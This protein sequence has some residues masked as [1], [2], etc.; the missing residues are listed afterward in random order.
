MGTLHEALDACL[1][2]D[3]PAMLKGRPGVGKTAYINQ[4]AAKRGAH[5]ETLIGSTMDPT[6]LGYLVVRGDR[7]KVDPPDWAHRIRDSLDKGNPTILF[8]DEFTSM[9]PSVMAAFL[10]VVNE[11]FVG[12]MDIRGCKII[13]AMNPVE[14]AAGG[15]DMDDASRNRW[16]FLEW[17]VD[18][19]EWFTGM[20]T[21][22]G[23]TVESRQADMSAFIVSFLRANPTCLL[24]DKPSG[25]GA[26]ESPRA[27][28]HLSRALSHLENFRSP[29]DA[30]L[31]AHGALLSEGLVGKGSTGVLIT[32]A[33]A[34]DLP[35]AE[36]L[37]YGFEAMPE[38]G[39]KQMVCCDALAV[40]A[41]KPHEKKTERIAKAVGIFE[42]LRS[43]VGIPA[44]C[45]LL[46]Q[47]SQ[48]ERQQ[49][50]DSVIAIGERLTAIKKGETSKPSAKKGKK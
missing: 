34:M 2:A 11:R 18:P 3:I 14:Q 4:L 7:V 10:R 25:D 17:Q 45:L 12:P 36:A 5:L 29:R 22:W 26:Y 47:L 41:L 20:L 48:K 27:W 40:E 1:R 32:F 44:A 31:S 37:L 49:L 46:Q 13:G 9:P 21:N 42:S 28:T 33:D 50:P 30:I 8:L 39:D 24:K 19:H 6:D 15:N 35:N 16:C 38:R 43:D 23:N